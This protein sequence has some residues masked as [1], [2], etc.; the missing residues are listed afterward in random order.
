M[1]N[2]ENFKIHI[3]ESIDDIQI[4]LHTTYITKIKINIITSIILITNE[5]PFINF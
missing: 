1:K 2:E 4:M 3:T 5:Q